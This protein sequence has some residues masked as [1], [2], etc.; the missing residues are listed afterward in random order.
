MVLSNLVATLINKFLSPFV[1]ELAAEQLKIFTWSGQVKLTDV[2]VKSNA[3][4]ALDLPCVVQ[5]GT[6]GKIEAAVPWTN[7]YSEPIVINIS[8]VY[9]VAV[10]NTKTK[11][12]AKADEE[13]EWIF[14]KQC[15]ENIEKAKKELIE[16]KL[17]E[18]LL[19][20]KLKLIF[21]FSFQNGQ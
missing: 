8:D 11:F 10:P 13:A 18:N 6:I 9:V 12:A 16:G 19:N 7:I 5:H 14:K 4:D 15:L 3:F 1:D 21:E 20:L 17:I 2:S